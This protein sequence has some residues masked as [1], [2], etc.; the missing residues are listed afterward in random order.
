MG[1]AELDKNL[2][3]KSSLGLDD[4][5]WY[6]VEKAPFVLYGNCKNAEKPFSRMPRKIADKVSEGVGVLCERPA[7]VRARFSTNSPYIAVKVE[8][9][10]FEP[11]GHMAISGSVG[12]DLYVDDGESSEYALTFVPPAH[13]ENGYE[14]MREVWPATRRDKDEN[15]CYT[16]NF[17]LYNEVS[18]VYVGIKAGSKI[19]RGAKYRDIP[20]VIYYGSS[21][22]QGACATRPGNAY[23]SM[24]A[25][26]LNVDFRNFGF[27]GNCKGEKAMAEYLSTLDASVFVCDYDHNTP[28]PEHLEET[29]YPFYEEYRKNRP[30]TPYV[31]VSRV[32]C[33]WNSRG[34]IDRCKDIIYRAYL[35]ARENGDD[36]VYFV[37]GSRIFEGAQRGSCLADGGHPTDIGF[38]RMADVIGK[39][40]SFIIERKYKKRTVVLASSNQHK[41]DE[42]TSILKKSVPGIE[43][44][45]MKEAGINEEIIENGSTFEENAMIKA[46]A[47]AKHGYIAIGDD[48]GLSVDALGGAPGIYSARYSGEHG[49]DKANNEKLLSELEGKENRQAKFVC[50]MAGAFPAGDCFYVKGEAKGEILK[51]MQGEGGFGYDPLFYYAPLGKTFAELTPEEKNKVSHRA[52]ALN[53][54]VQILSK[55]LIE[56]T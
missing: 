36:N 26:E 53:D 37:D 2:K 15:L 55:R 13:I 33:L 27:S 16:L 1:I 11:M 54:F 14:V 56:W 52:A 51:E 8:V 12:F 4:I 23:N 22:T 3:V 42:M 9:P 7:G 24:I 21:I 5:V 10:Y 18:K 49:N 44:I 29:Y 19:G 41:I 47:I 38:L 50:A 20:P 6:D 40:V 48:S 28:D 32:D 34:M 25:R 17:P 30:E 39:K 43:I 35:K 45:S 31:M 46:R